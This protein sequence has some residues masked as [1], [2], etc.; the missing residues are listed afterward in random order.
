MVR[1]EL[2]RR[3]ASKRN[4]APFA[5]Y[6]HDPIGFARTELKQVLWWRQEELLTSVDQNQLTMVASGQKTGKTRAFGGILP[7]WWMATRPRGKVLLTSGNADQVKLQLWSELSDVYMSTAFS[8]YCAI[9]LSVWCCRISAS[10]S[11]KDGGSARVMLP[12]RSR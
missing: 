1:D 4:V 3:D 8:R 2:L 10:I 6:V 11:V 9:S 12:P 7:L 5:R